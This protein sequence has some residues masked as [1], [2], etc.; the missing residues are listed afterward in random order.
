MRSVSPYWNDEH[1]ICRVAAT[2]ADTNGKRTQYAATICGE[3]LALCA[4]II[5]NG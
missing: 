5:A 1:E 2:T 4:E 3:C